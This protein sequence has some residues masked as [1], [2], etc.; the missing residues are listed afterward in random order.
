MGAWF[1]LNCPLRRR[2]PVCSSCGAPAVIQVKCPSAPHW[3]PDGS[4]EQLSPG[5]GELRRRWPTYELAGN[6][7]ENTDSNDDGSHA[8]ELEEQTAR[9]W[10]RQWW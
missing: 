1:S 3:R 7:D 4:L 6:S 8:D 5:S 2:G 10:P 9:E